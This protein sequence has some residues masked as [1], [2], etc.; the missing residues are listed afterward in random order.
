MDSQ[1]YNALIGRDEFFVLALLQYWDRDLSLDQWVDAEL[2]LDD[3]IFSRKYAELR[4]LM[5][6][7]LETQVEIRNLFT[8]ME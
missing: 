8:S 6:D 3:E 7:A 2:A 5:R 1:L 4:F